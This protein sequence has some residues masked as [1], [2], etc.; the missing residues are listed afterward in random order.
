MN[1]LTQLLAQDPAHAERYHAKRAEVALARGE[2]R[3]VVV[4]CSAVIQYHPQSASA[5][6]QR[7][8]AHCVLNHWSSATNDVLK[9][10]ELDPKLPWANNLLGVLCERAGC[11]DD[12]PNAMA[13][14]TREVR[15]DAPSSRP[16]LNRAELYLH[17]GDVA[18]ARADVDAAL[19][20][21]H[22]DPWGLYLR[23]YCA[24]RRGDLEAAQADLA[25]A[26]KRHTESKL[27]SEVQTGV[28]A[29]PEAH[30]QSVLTDLER[31][32]RLVKAKTSVHR[33][34]VDLVPYPDF[35]PCATAFPFNEAQAIRLPRTLAQWLDWVRER[36][37]LIILLP[38]SQR[39]AELY[40][41]AVA[42][43]SAL[44]FHVPRRFMTPALY[45]V[46]VTQEGMDIAH[47]PA[48]HMSDAVAR[49]IVEKDGLRLER[50]GTEWRGAE[51]CIAACRQNPGAW[52]FVPELMKLF[53]LQEVPGIAQAYKRFS[54]APLWR[55]WVAKL[56]KVL[57]SHQY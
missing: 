16:L 28:A 44:V 47:I 29:L 53:V 23:G 26:L 11:P 5:Y 34:P 22:A 41:L 24:A 32:E 6:L 31:N 35:H 46:A 1:V 51:V 52:A 8:H 10:L 37:K 57:G 49:A 7:A 19:R 3:L 4:D 38:K 45:T 42:Q 43:S 48:S 17:Q 30:S 20:L 13:A 27:T 15:L 33:T 54:T 9:A 14:Y 40:N 18:N 50:L 25:L 55:R 56:A 39:S 12:L 21:T 36:P 2:H